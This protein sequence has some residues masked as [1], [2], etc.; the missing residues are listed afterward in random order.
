MR[1]DVV[2][3]DVSMVTGMPDTEFMDCLEVLGNATKWSRKDLEVLLQH[4]IQVALLTL[5]R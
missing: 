4:A 3:V 2:M 5:C 1:Q